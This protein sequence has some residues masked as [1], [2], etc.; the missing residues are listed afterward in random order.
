MADVMV[1]KL[2]LSMQIEKNKKILK[3]I[4]GVSPPRRILLVINREAY[5]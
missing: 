4:S 5:M 1:M 3:M 2:V